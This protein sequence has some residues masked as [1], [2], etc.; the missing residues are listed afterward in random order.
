MPLKAKNKVTQRLSEMIVKVAGDRCGVCVHVCM[1]VCV[2][3][4]V[5]VFVDTFSMDR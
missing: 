4:R 5:F 3:V 1:C 2:C